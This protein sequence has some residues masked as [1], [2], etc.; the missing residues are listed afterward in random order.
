MVGDV[1][2]R[3]PIADEIDVMPANEGE[4]ADQ[5]LQVGEA[6]LTGFVVDAHDGD[7][8]PLRET[9]RGLRSQRRWCPRGDQDD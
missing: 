2:P 5:T 9:A 3:V 4:F 7:F 6:V 1:V 8:G